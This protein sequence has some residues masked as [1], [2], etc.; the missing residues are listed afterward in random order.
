VEIADSIGISLG[1]DM[2]RYQKKFISVFKFASI[3]GLISLFI[4]KFGVNDK[5]NVGQGMSTFI[6]N[7]G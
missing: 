5:F 4:K 1:N 2:K 6:T 7:A 3:H